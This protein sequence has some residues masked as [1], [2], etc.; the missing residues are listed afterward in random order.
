MYSWQIALLVTILLM[1]ALFFLRPQSGSLAKALRFMLAWIAPYVCITVAFTAIFM[2]TWP[3]ALVFFATAA[4]C[5]LTFI[6]RTI[7]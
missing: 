4:G 5:F 1:I 7:P 2:Q 6:R 3:I